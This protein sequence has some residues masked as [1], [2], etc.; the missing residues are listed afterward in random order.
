M[1]AKKEKVPKTPTEKVLTYTGKESEDAFSFIKKEKS[2]EKVKKSK[3]KEKVKKSKSKEKVKKV[4]KA[5]SS[6]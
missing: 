6:K 1:K 2:K 3:S 4:E 5:I